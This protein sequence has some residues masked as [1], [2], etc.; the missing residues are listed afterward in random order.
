MLIIGFL[1]LSANSSLLSYNLYQSAGQLVK[2]KSN[3]SV[4]AI[5]G[6]SLLIESSDP[7][8]TD[9]GGYFNKTQYIQLNPN[10]ISS[11]VPDLQNE[12]IILALIK[13]IEPGIIFTMH[14]E[15]TL[16]LSIKY[17]SGSLYFSRGGNSVDFF[18]NTCKIYIDEWVKA[19]I[20]YVG[21]WAGPCASS[22]LII[23]INGVCKSLHVNSYSIKWSTE[24]VVRFGAT[25]EGFAG[26]IGL[27]NA[28]GDYNTPNTLVSSLGNLNS[29]PNLY[30]TSMNISCACDSYSCD[31]N[32]S[33]ICIKCDSACEDLCTDYNKSECLDAEVL[34]GS[35]IYNSALRICLDS[36]GN[37]IDQDDLGD[38]DSCE[39]GYF[40]N[41][42]KSACEL[43]YSSCEYCI[44]PLKSDC[45]CTRTN[46]HFDSFIEKC[47]CNNGLYDL[48]TNSLS[49]IGVCDE[50][51]LTCSDANK[52]SCT[53]CYD[54]GYLFKGSCITCDP[55]CLS[56]LGEKNTDCI[57][58]EES[59]VLI[60]GTCTKLPCNPLCLTC[61]ETNSNECTSCSP[62]YYLENGACVFNSSC[63]KKCEESCFETCETCVGPSSTDC[64]TCKLL[65]FSV[66]S[67]PG[68]CTCLARYYLDYLTSNCEPC[69]QSCLTCSGP[70]FS[71]C[72]TCQNTNILIQTPPGK[73]VCSSGT[74]LN[75][76]TSN[77]EPC[78]DTCLTCSGP[79]IS[80]CLTCKNFDSIFQSS[81]GK[82]D[83]LSG[84]FLNPLSFNC[85]PC[86]DSCLACSVNSTYCSLC[87]KN[88]V[89]STTNA[90][91]KCDFGY[92]LNSEHCEKCHDNCLT[93][94][95][96]SEN[97]C[98]VCKNSDIII[99]NPPG[100]CACAESKYM[101]NKN[102]LVCKDCPAG[103]KSCTESKCFEC[104]YGYILSSL[105]CL[106]NVLQVQFLANS[107]Y[108]ISALFSCN[109]AKDLKSDD[110]Q[111]SI[112]SK[113]V[114]FTLVKI[115]RFRYLI[116]FTSF[117]ITNN[118]L[119]VKIE[120]ITKI[121]GE[122]NSELSIII[123]YCTLKIYSK[124]SDIFDSIVTI[125]TTALLLIAILSAIA[126]VF[127]GFQPTVIW[128]ALNTIQ[129]LSYVPLFNLPLPAILISFFTSTLPISILT[130][131]WSKYEILN[132]DN[133]D[134]SKKY[135]EYGFTCHNIITNTGQVL[136][137][138][139]LGLSILIIIL[140]LKFIPS[141][142]FKTY[143]TRNIR[144]YKYS[145]FFRFWIQHFLDVTIPVMISLSF[146]KFT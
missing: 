43:C 114:A 68:E 75:P 58:C 99:Y 104:F 9:R 143:I 17:E 97:S 50:S 102:P 142:N 125:T 11:S 115:N 66:R 127:T 120:I 39:A 19:I 34:C 112:E 119:K 90:C 15:N 49:C 129:L 140:P 107:N 109:L 27:F 70:T 7:I 105:K 77:C 3:S 117:S 133:S 25:S 89:L 71:D 64:L 16:R 1:I 2:D 84:F 106:K 47:V 40:L 56:C 124:G 130:N 62:P 21:Y 29:N 116:E 86:D 134:I 52:G 74:Y 35:K 31:S 20:G 59:K 4:Y 103:C 8:L 96:Y 83:C 24:S 76:S 37:C 5:L 123:Y 82:C 139:I 54:N 42:D 38:C 94:V 23:Q 135:Y 46:T 60:F 100:P 126:S 91:V 146:V 10:F 122:D 32:D 53:S 18:I 85:E 28:Y 108:S 57:S 95:G 36:I 138:F 81:L 12:L 101:S 141:L 79:G 111:I 87:K 118:N 45:I 80:N 136:L 48:G 113:I 73:C 69:D 132:C 92:Y 55:S 121:R 137:S 33:E 26:F 145:F 110:L 61:S 144:E 44:G 63:G 93:C 51:C 65:N 88:Y 67:P 14:V 22:G 41:S 131:I 72:L 128:M 98:L 78:D 30:L 6:S 13:V